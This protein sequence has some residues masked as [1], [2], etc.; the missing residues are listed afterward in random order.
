[1]KKFQIKVGQNILTKNANWKFNNISAKNFDNHIKKSVPLYD[2]SHELGLK[3]S[4]FFLTENIKTN[5]YDLGCSTGTFINKLSS[6][7]SNKKINYYGI[8]E[9]KDMCK[10][11]KKNNQSNKS[12]IILNKKIQNLKMLK[13]SFVTSFFTIQFTHPSYRQMIFKKVYKSL[14]WGGGF[15]VFEKVRAQ[16]A[17]FQDIITQLYNEYKLD[18]K[19][20]PN[21]II[22][23]TMS[24]KG[25]LEPFSSNAN[26][27]MFKRAGFKDVIT[28][29]KFLCF[30]GF[31]AIK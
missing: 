29:F 14:N 16:D 13:S 7:N 22:S 8:D 6:R 12:V 26:V 2:W 9:I 28:I 1:M 19:F 25:V 10:I 24:L 30:E 31:L 20:T 23:K 4:D 27:E 5:Y 15:L 3:V 17:R 18:Q 21:Q 11:S